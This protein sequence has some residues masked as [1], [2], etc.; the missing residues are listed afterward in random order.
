MISIF[1]MELDQPLNDF[2]G[3]VRVDARVPTG[4]GAT[5]GFTP[6]AG[7]NWQNVDDAAPDD[8]TTY[9]SATTVVTDTFVVQ[10]A[11][12]AGA[13]IFGVQHNLSMKKSDA[14]VCTV[15][16]V[17]RHSGADNVGSNINPSTSYGLAVNQTTQVHQ[18]SGLKLISMHEFGYKRTV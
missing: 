16:P 14:G 9:S 3:R 2:F 8:D 12:V 17:I 1:V 13:T 18:L 15:A 11:P 10:D 5:T 4:A 7:S 6:L